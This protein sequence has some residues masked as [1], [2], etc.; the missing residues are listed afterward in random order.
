MAKAKGF[1]AIPHGT[2]G[3]SLSACTLLRR[4]VHRACCP[5]LAA[6]RHSSTCPTAWFCCFI[7]SRGFF[8]RWRTSVL[9]NC[10]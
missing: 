1:G 8:R 6:V 5:R 10:V 2:G 4:G 9:P 3:I 7:T